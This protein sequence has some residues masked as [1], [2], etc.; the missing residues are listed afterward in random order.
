MAGKHGGFRA[1]ADE[2]IDYVEGRNVTI[3]YRYAD[4]QFERLTISPP[5][6]LAA[7]A[8]TSTI[9][10]AFV[11]GLDPVRTGLV[12]AKRNRASTD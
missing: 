9:P 11:V 6:A 8:P 1:R 12:T 10:I 2:V 7:K 4:G 5:A 3:E